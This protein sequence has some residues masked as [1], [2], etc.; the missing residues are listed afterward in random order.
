MTYKE[1]VG[2]FGVPDEQGSYLVA[3]PL[4]FPMRLAWDASVTVTRVRCHRSIAKALEAALKEIFSHYGQEQISKLG[5]D[6]FGGCF[7]YRATRQ[8][9]GWSSHSWGIAIDLDPDRNR[10]HYTN[11]EAAFARPKYLPLISIMEKH[12]FVNLGVLK[13]YDWMHFEKGVPA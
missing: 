2:A 9:R 13:N 3:I 4:P 8:G 5:I 11:K 10:L 7:N 12:G 1:K 6:R